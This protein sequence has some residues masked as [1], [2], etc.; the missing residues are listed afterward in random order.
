MFIVQ[1][2][3]ANGRCCY[4]TPCVW[5]VFL[6]QERLQSTVFPPSPCTRINATSILTGR[7]GLSALGILSVNMWG[8]L[9]V[10]RGMYVLWALRSYQT[11][12]HACRDFR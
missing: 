7:A 1:L 2:V 8:F 4:I 10:L 11:G 3:V 6:C 5:C 12:V 9:S